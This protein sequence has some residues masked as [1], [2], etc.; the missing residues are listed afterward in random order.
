MPAW[1]QMRT[2]VRERL[3]ELHTGGQ[4]RLVAAAWPGRIT[5]IACEPQEAEMQPDLV[6]R[7]GHADSA[8]PV[9]D[10]VRRR[11]E[12]QGWDGDTLRMAAPYNTDEITE[13]VADTLREAWDGD[14]QNSYVGTE[15]AYDEWLD[16]ARD[17][18]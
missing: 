18:Q 8:R 13:K 7:T 2:D 11:L 15:G 4:T 1:E 5:V 3:H 12:D 16:K 17:R 6:L 14:P 10:D 9:P